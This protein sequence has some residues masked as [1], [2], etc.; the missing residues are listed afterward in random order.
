MLHFAYS[1]EARPL[2]GCPTPVDSLDLPILYF[3]F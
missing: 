2:N 1:E 3:G